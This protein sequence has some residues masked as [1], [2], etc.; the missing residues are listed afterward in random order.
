MAFNDDDFFISLQCDLCLKKSYFEPCRTEENIIEME[1]FN[2]DENQETV[3]E[4]CPRQKLF[5]CIPGKMLT[6]MKSQ[7]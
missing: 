2:K 5:S 3:K 4:H 6:K 7:M 1:D